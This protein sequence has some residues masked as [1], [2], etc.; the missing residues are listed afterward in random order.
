MDGVN[1]GAAEGR[2]GVMVLA[3]SNKV[4]GAV[5]AIACCAG[6]NKLN[7]QGAIRHTPCRI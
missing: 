2:G 7:K 3:T 5:D 4:R 6:R 1:S